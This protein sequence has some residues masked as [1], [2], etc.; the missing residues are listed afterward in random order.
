MPGHVPANV[1]KILTVHQQ[2]IWLAAFEAAKKKYGEEKAY[3]IAMA[4]AKRGTKDS[5][6]GKRPDVL[7]DFGGKTAHKSKGP[8]GGQF[9]SGSGGGGGRS[10]SF[11]YDGG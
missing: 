5:R 9:T 11:R 2:E 4:A 8:G 10:G 3:A 6:G 7:A 1:Q